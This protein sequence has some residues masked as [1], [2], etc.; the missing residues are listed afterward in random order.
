MGLT[1]CQLYDET[2]IRQA[3]EADLEHSTAYKMIE[4]GRGGEVTGEYGRVSSEL[5]AHEG[6]LLRNS[7]YVIPK[8]DGKM[9]AQ[10]IIAAHEGHPGLSQIKSILRGAVFWPGMTKEIEEAYK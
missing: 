5:T 6:F 4:N 9:R 10:L 7:K 1:N 2:A 3:G 8:G